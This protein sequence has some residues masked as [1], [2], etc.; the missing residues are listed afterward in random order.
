MFRY[1]ANISHIIY[2]R[3]I[4][5]EKISSFNILKNIKIFRKINKFISIK[6]I[7]GI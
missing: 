6:D 2:G 5:P 7:N 4:T 1:D 3:Y